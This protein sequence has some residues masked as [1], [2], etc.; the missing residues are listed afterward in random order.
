M[1]TRVYFMKHYNN[2]KNFYLHAEYADIVCVYDFCDGSAIAAVAEYHRR[3]LNR[4][5]PNWKVF[6]RVF[7]NL[8]NNG[9]L[10]SAHISSLPQNSNCCIFETI[11]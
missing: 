10:P 1:E 4:R 3:F 6:T 2:A 7:N 9:V 5:T 8:R 11:E